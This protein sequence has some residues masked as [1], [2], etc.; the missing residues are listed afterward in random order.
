MRKTSFLLPAVTLVLTIGTNFG[1]AADKVS[2]TCTDPSD[3]HNI[4]MVFNYSER[5]IWVSH[6][7][8]AA[9]DKSKEQS[10]A[11]FPA[12]IPE[13]NGRAYNLS[14]ASGNFKPFS[15]IYK[16]A[17]GGCEFTF[18][19]DS[20]S[21]TPKGYKITTQGVGG[22]ANGSCEVDGGSLII[23]EDPGMEPL[24]KPM[25]SSAE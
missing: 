15:V 18:M 24:D 20:K 8:V 4:C 14:A 6:P 17:R 22:Y 9:Q 10:S 2:A 25:E 23:S 13:D 11:S 16:G 12:T 7:K 1:F 19:P 5:K 3:G 21:E